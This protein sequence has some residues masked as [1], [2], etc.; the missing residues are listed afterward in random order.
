MNRISHYLIKK[1]TS[2][3]SCVNL[4]LLCNMAYDGEDSWERSKG[5]EEGEMGMGVGALVA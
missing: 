3:D 1:I 2:K 5:I 4:F